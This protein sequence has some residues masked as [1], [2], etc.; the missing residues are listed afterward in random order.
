MTDE[1]RVQFDAEVTFL[2]GGGLQAQGFRL[3]IPGTDITD[4]ELAGMFIRSLSL[5]MVESVRFT[6]RQLLREPHKGSRGT[7]H[8]TEAGPVRPGP[9]RLIELSHTIRH[10]MVTY[11]GLP[12]PEITGHLS[13]ESSRTIY[14]PGCEFHIGRISMVANTGTYLDTPFHRYEGG[15]DLAGIPLASLAN[16]EG[17]VLRLAGSAQR[18]IDRA[19]FLPYDV[20]GK[21]VLVHTGWDRHWGTEQYGEGHPYLTSD[22]AEWLVA[23]KAALVGIDS[24]N[25]DDTRDGAR[26]VHSVL[27][28]AGIPIV[29]HLTGLDQVPVQGF[30]F[31][32]APPRVEGM[33]TFPVRAFAIVEES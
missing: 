6:N 26:P 33:G 1:W 23:Q 4:Q 2:N 3:D 7:E 21:A 17:L 16:L 5:L 25:I 27:L 14:A 9:R 12:G 31:H 24:L 15:A 19:A 32:A 29:E 28:A 22:A 13:R 30:R 18:A 10:G 20:A 8:G 11:P